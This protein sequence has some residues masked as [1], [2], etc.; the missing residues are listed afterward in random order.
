MHWLILFTLFSLSCLCIWLFAAVF[1]SLLSESIAKLN[2]KKAIGYIGYATITNNFVWHFINTDLS[3]SR[4]I[5]S[6]A[7]LVYQMRHKVM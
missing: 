6:C 5:A 4:I 3:D 7:K 2:T 1:F